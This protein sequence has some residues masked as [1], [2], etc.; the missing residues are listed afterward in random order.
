MIEV[1]PGGRLKM[2]IQ[3]KLGVTAGL[4]QASPMPCDEVEV[5]KV[6]PYGRFIPIEKVVGDLSFPLRGCVRL[7]WIQQRIQRTK[8]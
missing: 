5:A 7:D 4:D 3:V 1:I 6:F 2:L 8:A